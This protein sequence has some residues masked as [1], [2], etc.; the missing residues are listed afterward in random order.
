MLIESGTSTF[1][2]TFESD[3]VLWVGVD[4]VWTPLRPNM[5][6]AP[7]PTS[8]RMAMIATTLTLL[9]LPFPFDI[10][11]LRSRWIQSVRRNGQGWNESVGTNR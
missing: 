3:C 1:T 5:S 2:S 4:L 8:S 11:V 10:A 6:Q 9:V 7:R